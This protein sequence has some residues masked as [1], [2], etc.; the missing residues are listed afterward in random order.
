[1]LSS[2]NKYLW[3][4]TLGLLLVLSAQSCGLASDE[5]G[6]YDGTCYNCQTVCQGTAGKILDSCLVA[7]M[8]C[9]GYSKC[10]KSLAGGFDGMKLSMQEWTTTDC[11]KR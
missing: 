4:K 1:M 6:S 2:M 5:R 9:Q 11:Q 7:C 3:V 10:F 8:D